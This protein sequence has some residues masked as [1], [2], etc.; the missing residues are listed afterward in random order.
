MLAVCRVLCAGAAISIN[1]CKLY[2]PTAVRRA[3]LQAS[4][5]YTSIVVFSS[6]SFAPS[7]CLP[8]I[9]VLLVPRRRNPFSIRSIDLAAR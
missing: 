3:H 4:H 1:Y 5:G 7:V 8:L 9:R 2:A 6:L